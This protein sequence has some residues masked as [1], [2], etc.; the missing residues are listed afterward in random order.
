MSSVR[1]IGVGCLVLTKSTSF[2]CVSAAIAIAVGLPD[3]NEEGIDR[4][5]GE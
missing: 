5:D 2:L 1:R 4:R 3:S